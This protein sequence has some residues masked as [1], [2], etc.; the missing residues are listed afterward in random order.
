MP[1][2][3]T[4]NEP[5]AFAS[6]RFKQDFG[7][8]AVEWTADDVAAAVK[9][10][11]DCANATKKA[12]NKDDMAALTALWRS[13]G[14]LR[15][16]VGSLAA[17]EA[18]LDKGLHLLLDDPPSREVLDSLRVHAAGRVDSRQRLGF[19]TQGGMTGLIWKQCVF[20]DAFRVPDAG[21]L[22]AR[23]AATGHFQPFNSHARLVQ[24]RSQEIPYRLLPALPVSVR[25]L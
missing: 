10:T 5:T 4:K 18:K 12:R 13:F 15:A 22:T 6:P 17:S 9:A 24:C 25:V 16:T 21:P 1:P 2:R 19:E 14:G 7:L 20:V 11:G 8:P 3:A 23:S